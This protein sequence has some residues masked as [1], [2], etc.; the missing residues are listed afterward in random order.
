MAVIVTGVVFAV[1][2]HDGGLGKP[3][4]LTSVLGFGVSVTG[5]AVN[6][7]R[8]SS[9]NGTGPTSAERLD[10]YCDQLA[11]AVREQWQAEW[12]L[13][14]LQDPEPLQ[15]SW[16]L[17]EPWLADHWDNADDRTVLDGR[18]EH[19]TMVF[20]RVPSRRLVVL[21]GPGS[22]KTVLAV[23]FTLDVL[24][25][26]QPGETVPV[27]FSLS[28]WR[29][30]RESLR[31]WMTAFLAATYPGATWGGELLAAGRVLPVLDG[32]DEIPEPLRAQ[33]VHR[34]NAELDPGSPILLTCRTQVYADEVETGDVF[35]AAAVAELQP[36]SFDDA[37]AYL[38]RTARPVRGTD[39]QR[40][41]RWDPLLAR[42]RAHPN[43]LPGR[44]LRQVLGTPLM[45]AMARSVYGETTADP[46]ELLDPRFSDPVTLEQHL[47]EAFV[48]AAFRDAPDPDRA[49]RWLG[50]L[51]AHLERLHTRDLA[52]WQLRLA[53][54][55]PLRTLGPILLLGSL[56]MATSLAVVETTGHMVP[57]VTAA[58]LA[59]IS[60]GYLVLSHGRKPTAQ[61][62][63]GDQRRIPP[64]HIRALAIAACLGVVVGW[65]GGLSF[66]DGSFQPTADGWLNPAA[67]AM[68]AGLATAMIL[69]VIGITGAPL[70]STGSFGRS[71]QTSSS[72]R[73]TLSTVTLL[74]FGCAACLTA[75][76]FAFGFGTQNAFTLWAPTALLIT[77]AAATG[78]GVLSGLLGVRA[79]RVNPQAPAI[80]VRVPA[81]GGRPR[82][83][84]SRALGRGVA[85]GLV[86][87]LCLGVTFGLTEATV[88]AIRADRQG[89]Y[90]VGA[91]PHT[92]P[93]GTHY[94]VT[95]NGWWHGWLPDGSKFVR[96][97][98]SVHGIIAQDPDGSPYAGT[99]SSTKDI[100]TGQT[101][102]TPFYGPVEMR[103]RRGKYDGEQ[104]KLPSGTLVDEYDFE[105]ELPSRTEQWLYAGSPGHLFG[106]AATFG[107]WAG[108][109]IG[110]I[111]GIAAVLHRWLIAP[112]DITRSLSPLASLRSDRTTAAARSIIVFYFGIIT[113]AFLVT[114]LK[115][116]NSTYYA[117][118]IWGLA[119]PLAL[120]LSAW[121]WLLTAR[122]WLCG[123]S[124]LPWRLMAFLDEAHTRGV[125]RQAGAVYQFRHARLQEQLA[126]ASN[127]QHA[128]RAAGDGPT[129]N[130]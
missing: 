111:S 4:T 65:T 110:L 71:R 113:T 14:R 82:R 66:P 40:T 28:G 25:D 24:Q 38:I 85:A 114:L 43:D 21:G 5:L 18:L 29:P 46:A 59:G 64:E 100:C 7:F 13:R 31:G 115:L 42:V 15:V 83:R 74:L 58:I 39:G 124:R 112:V 3:E 120:V 53:L 107:L 63:P 81:Q 37:G 104:V 89:T 62:P 19:I 125:L 88:L 35:T 121:G 27:I 101:R 12:R 122:L 57:V 20:N 36:L 90:P 34:L 87:G 95:P 130:K 22:G 126:T 117:L 80:G 96:T 68:T 51:A 32:L 94:A 116:P 86:A 72:L 106:D 23:R 109:A 48:P 75:A 78:L 56:A 98:G 50:F 55:S 84:V 99:A 33:A 77:L 52:W 1:T 26:R 118:I 8:N 67:M 11:V 9:A 49:C 103:L 92:L 102:C 70:P 119:G 6:A 91:V 10:R 47:L 76:V 129:A 17:A 60:I 128:E 61:Q 73:R 41:T 123:T 44:A 45:V 16:T 69:A 97:P 30:D 105:N 108:L 54:P 127:H 79:R 93:D 2:A